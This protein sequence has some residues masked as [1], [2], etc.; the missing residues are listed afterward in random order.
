MKIGFVINDM[1]IEMADYST[2]YL[3]LTALRR[4]H[5]VWYISLDDF[6]YDPDDH[7]HARAIR[8]PAKRYRSE[9]RFMRDLQSPDRPLERISVDELDVM[10]LRNDPSLDTF[11]RPWARL[12]GINFGRLAAKQG[13][14]VLNDPDGLCH[15][16]N[17]VYL[18]QVPNA[19]RPRTLISRNKDDIKAFARAEKGQIVLKPLAGSGGRNVFLVRPSDMPNLNQMIE[20]VLRDGY[21]IAQEYLPEARFGDLRVFMMNGELLR[22]GNKIAAVRR[23]P[24]EGD[25]R[26]NITA[27]GVAQAEEVGNEVFKIAE[28]LRPRLVADGLFLVGLD[29]VG[30]KVMEV[31]VFSPGNLNTAGRLAG[32]DFLPEVIAAIERK[33]EYVRE[34]RGRY[35]NAEI[36][37]MC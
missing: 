28:L 13:V 29:V 19:V 26:S 36:A 12:A 30:D 15:A 14:I 7:V 11:Q 27:G 2:T 10:M 4:G 37:T 34:A 17:K 33:I 35:T 5:E 23:V 18:Q 3:A 16:I 21:V 25:M 31:N 8:A 1:A 24:H 22:K 9:V 20:S 6:A 32:V